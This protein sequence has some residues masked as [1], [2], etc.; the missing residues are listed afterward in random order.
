MPL[1]RDILL[2][3]LSGLTL[4]DIAADRDR[5]KLKQEIAD[6]LSG[7]I[8]GIRRVLINDFVVQ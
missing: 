5:E 4:E 2:T 6:S 3:T 7:V 8:G 1:V